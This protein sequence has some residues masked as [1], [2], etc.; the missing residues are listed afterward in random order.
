MREKIFVFFSFE[1][2]MFLAENPNVYVLAFTYQ[3]INVVMIL[4]TIFTLLVSSAPQYWGLSIYEAT[5]LF[6]VETITIVFFCFDYFVRFFSAPVLWRFVVS[7]L[8]IADALVIVPYFVQVGLEANG[9]I[10]NVLNVFNVLKL[11]RLIRVWKLLLKTTKWAGILVPLY[12]GIIHAYDAIILLVF[13]FLISLVFSSTL[14]FFSEQTISSFNTTTNIWY[15]NRD[16]SVTPFQSIYDSFWW[17]LITMTFIGYGDIAPQSELAKVVTAVTV[18]MALVSFV[19]P[20]ALVIRSIV[21]EVTKYKQVRRAQNLKNMSSM[22][23]LNEIIRMSRAIDANI[24]D[25]RKTQKTVG[26]LLFKLGHN[27]AKARAENPNND[28]NSLH[29]SLFYNSSDGTNRVSQLNELRETDD[30][31]ESDL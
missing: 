23:M 1:E 27:V 12:L 4:I 15:Y 31:D 13:F 18:L 8:N 14:V 11:L 7:P 19:F 22:D 2:D 6:V 28:G 25:L 21:N 30:D 20:V 5:G 24:R 26:L 17:S 16:G 29:N 10:F 3:I 9:I